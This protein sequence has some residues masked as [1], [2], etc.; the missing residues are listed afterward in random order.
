MYPYSPGHRFPATR[1]VEK[2]R[3]WDYSRWR[4]VQVGGAP[5]YPMSS[6][7]RAPAAADALTCFSTTIERPAKG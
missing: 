3:Q 1:F 7:S 2:R 4:A 6:V 5:A